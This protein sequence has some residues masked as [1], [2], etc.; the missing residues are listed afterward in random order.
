MWRQCRAESAG[1]L[2]RE[3]WRASYQPDGLLQVP[4]SAA[5]ADLFAESSLRRAACCSRAP[6][7]S[8]TLRE[9]KHVADSIGA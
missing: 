9:E 7:A 8:F 3:A 6:L 1:H 2:T 5:S 4:R